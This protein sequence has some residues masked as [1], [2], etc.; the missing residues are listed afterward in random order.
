MDL[1]SL[2]FLF[3]FLP[4]FLLFYLISTQQL[5]KLVVLVASVIFLAWGEM[6]AL[7]WLGGY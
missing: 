7:W 4:V 5:R 6:L 2:L 1:S 3:L